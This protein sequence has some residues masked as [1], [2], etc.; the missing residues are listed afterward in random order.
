MA[1]RAEDA[2]RSLNHLCL[3]GRGVRTP[4][5][6][7]RWNK[8]KEKAMAIIIE[9]G[10]MPEGANSY[11]TIEICDQWQA[12]R[13]STVWLAGVD[14]ERKDA[15]LIRATDYLNGLKWV[16]RKA[17]PGRIM[18]WPRIDASDADGWV[19]PPDSVPQAVVFAQCYLAGLALGG[20]D[21]QP[22][23]ERGGRIQSEKV[24]DLNTT[25]FD[26]AADRDVYTV[27]YDLLRGLVL[28]LGGAKAGLRV[29]KLM[30]G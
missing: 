17:A 24:G 5:P 16:G 22:L 13:G 10:T 1:Q 26:D 14:K 27:L 6:F 12:E 20:K 7:S 15:A 28:N 4:R 2:S 3:T 21:L 11:A 29:A 19:V 30:M 8:G 18:A 25:Y 9:D 23:L